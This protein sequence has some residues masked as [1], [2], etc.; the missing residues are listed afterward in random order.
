[1][2]VGP[3]GGRLII[4]GSGPLREALQDLVA[5]LDLAGSVDFLGSRPNEFPFI[6]RA[7][8][9]LLSSRSEGFGNVIAEG[10]ASPARRRIGYAAGAY[11]HGSAQSARSTSY[12]G[13]LKRM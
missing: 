6:R 4:L 8:E 5:K 11:I 7:D 10:V 3:V 13:S 1:M 2:S 9:F 12:L